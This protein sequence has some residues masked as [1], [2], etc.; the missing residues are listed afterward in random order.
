MNI[1]GWA[2]TVADSCCRVVQSGQQ[3]LANK[4]KQTVHKAGAISMT[5][6]M[7]SSYT[8]VCSERLKRNTMEMARG[9]S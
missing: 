5:A 4:Q 7:V 2:H 8:S 3:N 1:Q 9:K 6:V